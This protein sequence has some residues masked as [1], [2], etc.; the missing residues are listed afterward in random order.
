MVVDDPDL[1]TIIDARAT[2]AVRRLES[3]SNN[4]AYNP[5]NANP[6]PIQRVTIHISLTERRRKN[7][8]GY[9]TFSLSKPVDEEFV[10]ETWAVSVQMFRA[11]S[12]GEAERLRRRMEKSLREAAFRIIE[13]AGGEKDHIPPITTADANPFPYRIVVGEVG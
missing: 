5:S 7:K 12:E 6:S 11:R 10:W 9:F 1:E 8:Q 2:A 13:L 4:L 3:A